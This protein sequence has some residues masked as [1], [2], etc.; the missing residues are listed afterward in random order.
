MDL[1]LAFISSRSVIKEGYVNKE[2]SVTLDIAQEKP[3]GTIYLIPI[4]LDECE[5]PFRLK[6]LNAVRYYKDQESAKK[7]IVQAMQMRAKQ[8]KIEL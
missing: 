4:M 7:R 5:L 2:L 8:R 6:H 1:V 3:E